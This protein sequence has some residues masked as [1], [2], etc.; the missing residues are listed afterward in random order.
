[1]TTQHQNGNQATPH[2]QAIEIELFLYEQGFTPYTL[3]QS[4]ADFVN[5]SAKD[6][7]RAY[8]RF[9]KS[10]VLAGSAK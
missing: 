8:L 1:M 9:I 3:N 10:V 7:G 4:I 6:K 2:H 5:L